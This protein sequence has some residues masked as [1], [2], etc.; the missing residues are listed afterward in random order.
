GRYIDLAPTRIVEIKTLIDTYDGSCLD[1]ADVDSYLDYLADIN[2]PRLPWENEKD[3][4]D[5][6][7][8][9]LLRA[10]ELEE[11]IDKQ[12]KGQALHIFEL[13]EK[14]LTTANEYNKEINL[15]REVIKTLNNDLSILQERSLQ[16]VDLYINKLQELNKRRRSLSGQDPLKL[17]WYTTLTLMALDDAIEISPN[18]SIGDDNIPIFTAPAN[19]PDIECYYN[20][21][22][23]VCEVT[24]L[25][26]RD[27]WYNEGQ[28]VMRHLRDFEERLD[29]GD[30]YCLFI[31]PII[32]RDTLNTFWMSIKMGYEGK[33]QRIIPLTIEQYIRVL[34]IVLDK[35][36]SEEIR[37]DR[38]H[39][40]VL[41]QSLVNESSKYSDS[42]D[43]V[44]SIDRVINDW[45]Y[46]IC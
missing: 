37:V 6:Y 40:K 10:H 35:Y 29:S 3:L 13:S 27:Q 26:G 23:L 28:P 32:H 16:N 14:R 15:L 7:K 38:T 5:V 30:N 4:K 33:K 34:E 12:Y 20:G 36:K 25:K 41:L 42:N 46:C 11:T 19:I 21:F 1:F 43:W 9:L 2:Q 45:K 8:N 31:A 18:Y 39:L 44:N 17:E 24:L 22:N